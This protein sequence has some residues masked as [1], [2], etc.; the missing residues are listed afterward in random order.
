MIDYLKHTEA[1]ARR[2]IENALAKGP[3]PNSGPMLHLGSDVRVETEPAQVK[4]NG[5]TA[6]GLAASWS[7]RVD[8]SRL[9][10]LFLY[11]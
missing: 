3:Q 7:G 10:A 5:A 9:C 1:I 4:E 8:D 11:N 6:R 2:E